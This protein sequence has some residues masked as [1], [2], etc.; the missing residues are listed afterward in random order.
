MAGA[1]AERSTKAKAS[2][3]WGHWVL[4]KVE[5]VGP[6]SIQRLAVRAMSG[7]LSQ[8]RLW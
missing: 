3:K 8:R 5:A 6:Q 4:A 7:R 1:A 2:S